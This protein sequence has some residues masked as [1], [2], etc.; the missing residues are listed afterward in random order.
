MY[1]A[2]VLKDLTVV[3]DP[4]PSVNPPCDARTDHA[5]CG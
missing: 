2:T 1:L 3:L 5:D 4:L